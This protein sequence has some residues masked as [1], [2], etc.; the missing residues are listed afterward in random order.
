ME[1]YL[2]M[3]YIVSKGL[4]LIFYVQHMKSWDVSDQKNTYIYR[5]I[6]H[7][8][9]KKW[10]E[11][12]IRFIAIDIVHNIMFFSFTVYRQ[13][14][15]YSAISCFDYPSAFNRNTY[16]GFCRLTDY[17]YCSF[18]GYKTLS[19]KYLRKE[20]GWIHLWF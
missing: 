13:E 12:D 17:F 16:I 14:R 6:Y 8:N 10:S 3:I 1:K 20:F 2:L 19:V 5:K 15:V 9:R 7:T 18:N 4:F 11:K